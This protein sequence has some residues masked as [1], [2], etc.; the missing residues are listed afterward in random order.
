[1]PE[2]AVA[3]VYLV[4]ASIYI[5]QSHFSPYVECFDTRGEDL[6]ALFGFS[7]FLL[8]FMQRNKP[9][10]M[11]VAHDESLFCGFRHKL[12]PDYKSNRELPDDNLAMQLKACHEICSVLGLPSFA[13][14]EYE[15][16][17]IIGTLANRCRQVR[18][19]ESLPA[20][21]IVSRDKDLGQLLLGES[22]CV[23]D[24]NG[25]KRRYRD[26]IINE[27]GV[28]PECLPDYLGLV[29]DS[30]DCIS[31]VP[32]VGPVKA[33][34]L[35]GRYGTLENLYEHLDEVKTLPLR[36][37]AS[38]ARKLAEHQELAELSKLLATIICDID[39]EE[40]SCAKTCAEDLQL[41]DFSEAD[42]A[43]FL[44]QYRFDAAASRRLTY[45]AGRLAD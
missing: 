29:G 23:W 19:S 41:G 36:G 1:M 22:D 21:E 14:R 18:N 9:R 25:N 45:L 24:Y 11:A 40:E 16:D 8:Q 30:V 38:L 17:D 7:Q 37:A 34:E 33:K 3:P 42:F 32:G 5:F 12:C 4:D 44:R 26:D 20:V 28:S 31:G 13:S 2:S 6:S 43:H 15:A 10:A 35:L 27:F 39:A